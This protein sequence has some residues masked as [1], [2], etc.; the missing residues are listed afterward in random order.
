MFN[1]HCLIHMQY[2][3]KKR[4]LFTKFN[5]KKSI[6]INHFMKKTKVFHNRHKFISWH[7]IEFYVSNHTKT[8]RSMIYKLLKTVHVP[9]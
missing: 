7:I 1:T 2:A 3:V 4:K 9:R 6:V 5:F 8:V